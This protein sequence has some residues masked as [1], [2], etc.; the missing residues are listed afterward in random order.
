MSKIQDARAC[1]D[2]QIICEDRYDDDIFKDFSE[3]FPELVSPPY[4]G[5]IKLNEDM[6]KSADGKK[7]WREFIEAY[8]D[9]VADYNFGSLIRTNAKDEYAETN[10][11]FGE[12]MVS[13]N[14]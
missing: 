9:K 8:K 1:P 3:K 10:T 2:V 6:M 7:R 11:I 14:D 5:L 4:D 13:V 12:W